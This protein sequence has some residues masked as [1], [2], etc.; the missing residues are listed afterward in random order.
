[1]VIDTTQ[2]TQAMTHTTQHTETKRPSLFWLLTEAGR[3]TAEWGLSHPYRM[4]FSEKG[5][6]DGHPVIVIPGFMSTDS[7]TANLRRHINDLGYTAL[8]WGMGRNY[9]RPEYMDDLCVR[10]CEISA[11]YGCQVSVIGWSLGGIFARQLGKRQPEEVRQ[12]I[13]MGSP[14]RG[15][16]KANNVAWIYNFLKGTNRVASASKELLEDLP[17]PAPVPTTAI[18]S[19]QDGIVPW[20]LCMEIEET[21]IH[22]NVEVRGSHFGLGHNPSVMRIIADR[23]QYEQ[24]NWTAFST[25]S[26]LEDWLLYPSASA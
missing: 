13:T 11:K 22:Q 1:M 25:S 21:S 4:L 5:I 15:V 2:Y 14:F 19:K 20:R 3:A 23:L 16:G 26:V 8:G 17:K 7:S 12:I 24:N 9:G 6:G 18:Y 10:V